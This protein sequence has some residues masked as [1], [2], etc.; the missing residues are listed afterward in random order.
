MRGTSTAAGSKTAFPW[1]SVRAGEW[2]HCSLNN[3]TERWFIAMGVQAGKEE[4]GEQ[5]RGEL[6]LICLEWAPG[7]RK[8]SLRKCCLGW[9]PREARDFTRGRGLG[10]VKKGHEGQ[11]PIHVSHLCQSREEA[12]NCSDNEFT[13]STAVRVR[14]LAPSEH[15]SLCYF[16]KG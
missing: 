11:M 16:L 7:R 15:R 4:L 13:L 3:H 12:C 9:E 14:G 1:R 10:K 8:S 6:E 2:A 5:M